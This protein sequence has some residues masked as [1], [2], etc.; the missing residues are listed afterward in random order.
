MIQ[1][2]CVNQ[3]T[4]IRNV[5]QIVRADGSREEV[6]HAIIKEHFMDIYVQEQL[7]MKLICTQTDLDNLVVGRLCTEAVIH[8]PEEIEELSICESGNRARVFLKEDIVF[9]KAQEYEPTCCTGNEIRLKNVIPEGRSQ[10]KENAPFQE[11]WI[12]HLA[13][14][15]AEGSMLHKKTKGT[16]CCYLAV[17]NEV[18]YAAED[19]GRHNALDKAIGYALLHGLPREKCILYTTGR[20]P[21]DM[22]KKVITAGFPTLVSKA[23][24]TDEAVNIARENHL[25]LICRAW[26]D[27]FEIFA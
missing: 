12:F 2:R 24:P 27:S 5:H 16:H 10:Y 1:N 26:P 3:E 20:V 17:E 21:T 6:S 23:V 15:F 19:I 13:S 4:D 22:V 9:Q 11:S 18:V 25:N 7:V 14:V 8:S